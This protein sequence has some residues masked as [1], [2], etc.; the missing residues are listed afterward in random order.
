MKKA[1]GGNITQAVPLAGVGLIQRRYSQWLLWAEAPR[2]GTCSF[3]SSCLGPPG[4]TG[5]SDPP[6]V[7]SG[8]LGLSLDPPAVPSGPAGVS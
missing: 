5:R 8:P 3:T 7:P 6:G 4:F 1:G 2:Y